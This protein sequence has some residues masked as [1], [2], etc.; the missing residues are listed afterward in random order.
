MAKYEDYVQEQKLEDE[1]QEASEQST[2]R[3][4]ELPPQ[5]AGKSA[6][7]VAQSYV[8]LKALTDRQANELGELRKTTSQL[9]EQLLGNSTE[10]RQ[11]QK[12]E[13]QPITVDDLYD[14]PEEA[15]ARVASR[16]ASSRQ[17][18]LEREIQHLKT[19]SA[20]QD[21]ER[22]FPKMMEDAQ[23][24]EMQNW[25]SQSGYRQRMAAAADRGDF[26]AAEELFG[27][28]Y[29]LTSAER[30]ETKATPDVS[31]ATLE[32]GPSAEITSTE[33]FSRAKL[34]LAR[35]QARRGDR[36]AEAYLKANNS[37]I[38]AAYEEGRIVD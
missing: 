1:I 5:F 17:E 36:E 26:Q 38:R 25:I 11:E 30:Q 20:M 37:A 3:T 23:S 31:Q 12:E 33:T 7:E 13:Y 29:D 24:P 28:Y 8:E 22:K 10:T 16:G 27:M 4:G 18:E 14:N 15:I 34:E 32:S 19:R 35:I 21:L 6:E 2:R 9:T